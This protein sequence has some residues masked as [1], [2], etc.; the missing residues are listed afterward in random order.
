L[1]TVAF[2]YDR[3][4]S[5]GLDRSSAVLSLGGGVTG[6]IAGFAAA[7]YMRGVRFV[8]LP[9]TLLAM[10][11]AS[12]GGKT[13]VD[14]PQGKNLVGAFKQPELVLI[15]PTVLQ[16]LSVDEFRSGMAEVIKHGTIGAPDL[17]DALADSG[18]QTTSSEGRVLDSGQIARALQVKID[19][20]EQDPFETG[21]RA[22]LN[23]G[24]TV[25][26]ALERLSGFSLRHG[27]AV[28]IGMVAAAFIAEKLG[29]AQPELPRRIEAALRNWN[30]PV[31][32]P[33]YEIG[34]ILHAMAHDKKQSH[35][36]LRWV[37]PHEIGDVRIVK[38]VPLSLVES[39]LH[40]MG[41]RADR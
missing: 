2:L 8:Q 27:E 4:L 35:D 17:F 37:L 21:R 26:H 29:R 5:I 38:D 32:C 40:E 19:V 20:V 18:P 10:I 11:D 1:D 3:F 12:V 22:V 31:R 7:S 6:D 15:D 28:A 33:P 13:G 25:G 41:G 23:L 34:A 39:V 36:G 16:S 24:H 9:T 30:L 14:L